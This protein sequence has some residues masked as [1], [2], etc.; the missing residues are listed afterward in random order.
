MASATSSASAW[1][2]A[3]TRG[4]AAATAVKRRAF[5]RL[6]VTFIVRSCGS[7]TFPRI[8]QSGRTLAVTKL[9]EGKAKETTKFAGLGG[10]KVEAT[11]T[12]CCQCDT[13]HAQLSS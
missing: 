3:P 2:I 12:T 8:R 1:E 11:I 13:S 7:N 10:Q 6:R 4:K 5:R 9:P